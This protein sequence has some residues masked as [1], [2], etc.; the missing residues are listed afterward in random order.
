MKQREK[1]GAC[2]HGAH[3]SGP[4]ATVEVTGPPSDHPAR[5]G[6]HGDRDVTPCNCQ[7]STPYRNGHEVV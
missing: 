3:P 1:C 7:E 6:D 4:C 5:E 2:Y